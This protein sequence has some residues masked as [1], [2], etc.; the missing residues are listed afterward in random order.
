MTRKF[1]KKASFNKWS[2]EKVS[3]ISVSYLETNG[4]L[5]VKS[6]TKSVFIESSNSKA[7][8]TMYEQYGINN[9]VFLVAVKDKF[10]R[11]VVS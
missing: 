1:I 6:F 8:E 4:K 5:K 2:F 3:R 11:L 7:L 9:V 10:E